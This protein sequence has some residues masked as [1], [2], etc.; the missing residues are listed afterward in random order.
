MRWLSLGLW[1]LVGSLT[2]AGSAQAA[3]K[4]GLDMYTAKADAKSLAVIHS[5]G[6]DVAESHLGGGDHVDLVLTAREA[7][8][9]RARDVDVSLKRNGR[10]QTVRQQADAMAASG[11]QVYR[12]YDEAGGIRDELYELAQRNPTIVKLVVIGRT[13]QGRD[14]IALKLTRNARQLADGARPAAL[15]MGTI[16]AREWIATE[17]TR[18]LLRHFVENY[19]RNAE[20][21]NLVNTRELWF[22]PVANPDGYQYTHTTERLWRKNLRDNNGDGTIT[23]GDGVDLNRN[24]DERWNYDN[25]GSSTESAS[26]TYRGTRPAS[27]PETQAHQA[28]F[29]RMKFKFLLTYHSYGPL[30]LYPYGWQVKTPSLDDPLF[31]EYTG[32]DADPAVAGYDP[33][34]GADLY[35][36][37]GTTDDYAYSKTGALSWTPEL[38]EG[39]DGCGFVFPDD[40]ALVQ[41]EFVKNLPFAM[42]LARSTLDPANPV[43]ATMKPFYLETASLDPEKSG[44][45]LSNLKFSVSY[46]DPQPAQVIAKRSL[47]AVSLKYRINGGAVRTSS[48]SEASG[49]ERY[50][51]GGD[52][53]YRLMRG[54]VTGT[55]VGDQVE[56]WFEDADNSAA[57]SE[58]FTY[59]AVAESGRRVLVVAAEDYTGISPVYK[60]GPST[61]PTTSTRSPPT[62]SPPTSMTS[63]RTAA[64]RPARS[65]CSGTTT[66]SSGTRATSDHA[67]PGDGARDGVTPCERRDAGHAPVPR[68]GRPAPVRRQ[69]RGPAVRRRVRVRPRARAR[70]QPRLGGRRLRSAVG[71]LPAVLPGR[72]YLQRRRRHE[73]ERSAL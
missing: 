15:Y 20:I 29:N 61:C 62:A 41:A 51:P 55:N 31:V 1:V 53:Y 2:A 40:E 65:A 37:N 22:M 70:L 27:E 5:G 71:R 56:V 54:N 68:G 12:S 18:R 26:D 72:V 44:N 58:S 14:I 38:S 67:R 57:K 52:V 32:T 30:L 42:R 8:R 17:V 48:T 9:L 39:C 13:L 59:T 47:G 34:V 24:Y 6:Y 4:H 60:R 3:S 16:H 63:T 73:G 36:T 45:P 43:G 50:G 66:R 64:G 11:Y 10:G 25:E 35:T 33:G 19:G 23:T 28:L 49:G 7:D 21:T 46:G 69:E